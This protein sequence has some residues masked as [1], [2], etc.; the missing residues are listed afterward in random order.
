MQDGG[1]RGEGV[2]EKQVEGSEGGGERE[3]NR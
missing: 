1:G 3:R 2:G